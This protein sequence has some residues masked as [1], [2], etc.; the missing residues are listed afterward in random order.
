MLRVTDEQTRPGLPGRSFTAPSAA[1]QLAWNASSDLFYIRSIDGAIIPYTF[2]A[3][4][5]GRGI[6]CRPCAAHGG[7]RCPLGGAE[8]IHE[9]GAL[10]V[11][12]CVRKLLSAKQRSAPSARR[13]FEPDRVTI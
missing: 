5:I 12:E 6:S 8:C 9:I 2:D 11:F 1:H 3:I 7:R 10:G 4:V 13:S